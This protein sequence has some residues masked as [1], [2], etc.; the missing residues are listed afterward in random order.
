KSEKQHGE[1]EKELKMNENEIRR[2]EEELIAEEK[3]VK[4]LERIGITNLIQTFFGSK[5]EKLRQ[6]K[7]EVI[8][9][10]IQLEEALKTQD[11]INE[12]MNDLNEKLQ[13]VTEVENDYAFLLAEKEKI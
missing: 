11:E 4:K 8:A 12:A 2:I 6:E 13:E 3:D 5:H 1:Y 9:V 7:Q 10:Q